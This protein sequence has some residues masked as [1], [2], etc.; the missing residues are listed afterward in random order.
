MWPGMPAE[1]VGM[2]RCTLATSSP[3]PKKF[4]TPFWRSILCWCVF[5]QPR[6][7]LECL[8]VQGQ[9]QLPGEDLHCRR[10]CSALPPTRRHTPPPRCC[11]C[12]V[13]HV[14]CASGAGQLAQAAQTQLRPGNPGRA[15]AH[16]AHHVAPAGW[17]RELR[18]GAR[19]ATQAAFRHWPRLLRAVVATR[20]SYIL[21]EPIC[22]ARPA[23]LPA[24]LPAFPTAAWPLPASSSPSRPAACYR[25]VVIWVLYSSVTGYYFW[26]CSAKKLDKEV[27]KQVGEA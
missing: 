8:I 13:C 15:V 25:F 12:A 24:R 4:N 26:R 21:A 9:A 5:W 27:P 23:S 11:V 20:H 2:S 7:P 6:L 1:T 16:S 19:R 22:L 3:I 10:R 18:A 14:F 17:V